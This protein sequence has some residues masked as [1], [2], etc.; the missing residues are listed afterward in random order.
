MTSRIGR[1]GFV[2]VFA[3][4][5]AI[6]ADAQYPAT[7]YRP[8]PLTG[9][10]VPQTGYNPWTGAGAPKYANPFTGAA[11]RP[12]PAVNPYTARPMQTA[13]GYN[14][15]TG[16]LQALGAVPTP[17]APVVYQWPRGKFPVTGKA[18]PGLELFDSLVQTLMTRH[19]IPGAALV[20]AKDGK[21]VYAK[22]FGWADLTAATPVTP[23]TMFGL[24]SLSKPLT[25]LAILWLIEH[26]FLRLD[27]SVFA[28][29]RDI[30][31]LPGARVDP[32]L[33]NI[34]IRQVLNHTGGWDRQK[35]GDPANWEPQIAQAL[36]VPG[37][38]SPAQFI[39]FMMGVPLDFAPGTRMEYSNV[40]YIILGR[41]IEKVSGQPYEDFVRKHVLLPAGA[42]A[43][44]QP[45]RALVWS[46]GGAALPG[47]YECALAA[48][49]YAD[50]ARRRRLERVGGRSGARVDRAG[51]QPRQG[52][53]NSGDREAHADAAAAAA[54]GQGERLLQRARLARGAHGAG[55]LR[56]R[57]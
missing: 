19:G 41:I 34:T 23:R 1:V 13:G 39:S 38:V 18:G 17:T 11:A 26:G 46:R 20:I 36:G 35:S 27:D 30:Q 52:A 33:K 15:L 37:H 47:G 14:A 8:N 29:L 42:G 25:A 7:G 3:N 44:Y 5:L 55:W 2:L 54:Q 43:V 57:S 56:L 22:G 12:G 28:I 21:L 50:G 51:R 24:A 4:I 31:P 9:G 6:G 45:R 49:G 48:D 53:L 10:Y 16:K 40:G 32:R